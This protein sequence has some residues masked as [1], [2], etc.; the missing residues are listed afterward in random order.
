MS[1]FS[2]QLHVF[3]FCHIIKVQNKGSL[4]R[5]VVEL[6]TVLLKLA[7]P[8]ENYPD[9]PNSVF[10]ISVYFGQ[11][12]ANTNLQKSETERHCFFFLFCVLSSQIRD[13]YISNGTHLGPN[14]TTCHT[15]LNVTVFNSIFLSDSDKSPLS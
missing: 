9:L 10:L 14:A 8:L 13:I 6:L 2:I 11:R 15:I 1:T 5:N 12:S 4:S 7:M 3:F